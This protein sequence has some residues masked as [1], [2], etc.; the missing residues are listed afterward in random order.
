MENISR[1]PE[2]FWVESTPDTSRPEWHEGDCY[3]E[4]AWDFT[5]QLPKKTCYGTT[6]Y[7]TLCTVIMGDEI[8]EPGNNFRFHICANTPCTAQWEASKYGGGKE[9]PLHVVLAPPPEA[10]GDVLAPAAA[11]EPAVAGEHVA[12]ALDPAP[13][14]AKG[15]SAEP[16]EPPADPTEPPAAPTEEEEA[17]AHPVVS[18]PA[19]AV[20]APPAAPGAHVP[21]LVLPSELPSPPPP[22]PRAPAAAPLRQ[23]P[24]AA[25]AT[26]DPAVAKPRVAGAGPVQAQATVI[27]KL[28]AFARRLR[29]PRTTVG[30]SAFLLFALHDKYRCRPLIWEGETVIDLIHAYAPWAKTLC[31]NPCACD[32]VACAI[33]ARS[34]GRADWYPISEKHPLGDTRH[35]IGGA[36]VEMDLRQGEC[37]GP[38]QEFY[39]RLG[40]VLF[41]TVTDNDCGVDTM[42]QMLQLPQ[43]PAKRQELRSDMSEY[44]L[45]R[46]ESPWMQ[47]LMVA[48]C[49]L[50][51][52]EVQQARLLQSAC[53]GGPIVVADDAP[54][55]A[56][57]LAPL[58]PEGPA[59]AGHGPSGNVSHASDGVNVE[60]QRAL[61]P[62]E[63]EHEKSDT[64]T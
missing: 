9:A 16:A 12:A 37:E 23:Y 33:P 28:I 64:E 1:C 58:G 40:L 31:V 47:D 21:P 51:H 44:L 46:L 17:Y 41:G 3:M 5:Q 42:C 34:R 59:V 10:G 25:C 48:T 29:Q 61:F 56:I 54:A 22:K 2:P 4:I 8:A 50:D 45:E 36:R 53:A 15:P 7:A 6:G 30:Y 55:A 63:F 35:W 18:P 27:A 32:A 19:P 60:M 52:K 39:N 38:L 43:T 13:V 62:D 26:A 14:K 11:D 24:P 57:N 20:V 49:E